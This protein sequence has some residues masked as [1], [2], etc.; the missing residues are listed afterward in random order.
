MCD[1]EPFT[2]DRAM[3]S[4]LG[5]TVRLF[6]WMVFAPTSFS[7]LSQE[8]PFKQLSAAQIT[9]ALSGKHVT[10]DHHWGHH[11]LPDGRVMMQE[12]G[13]ERLGAWSV[14]HGRLCLLKPQINKTEPIC[15]VVQRRGNELRYMSDEQVVYRG[16]IRGKADAQLF[17]GTSKPRLTPPG[18]E[19]PA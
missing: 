5:R 13:R 10:D 14:Q 12:S 1:P 18:K 9:V 11:Y 2:F 7:A 8:A 6:V 4:S 15:H 17:H 3:P 19:V 16:F